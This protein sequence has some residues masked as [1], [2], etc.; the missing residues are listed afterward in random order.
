[1]NHPQQHDHHNLHGGGGPVDGGED[2]GDNLRISDE[3]REDSD[4]FS[5]FPDLSN[6]ANTTTTGIDS[7][8]SDSTLQVPIDT[9][10][11]DAILAREMAELTM[12]DRETIQ[13]SIYGVAPPVNESEES[14][15][16]GLTQFD[17]ILSA[18]EKEANANPS[19]SLAGRM[20]AYLQAKQMNPAVTADRKLRLSFL[21][22]SVWDFK[23][24]ERRIFLFFTKKLNFFG[25]A[26]LTRLI[27]WDDL[28][29]R[30]KALV[31]SGTMSWLPERDVSGR[32]VMVMI[33][34]AIH[35]AESQL[36]EV[37]TDHHKVIRSRLRAWN[38]IWRELVS[39]ETCHLMGVVVVILAYGDL[40]ILK[41][42][43]YIQETHASKDSG[44]FRI[45]A[46]HFCY[47]NPYIRPF[48]TFNRWLMGKD[49]RERNITHY[50][51]DMNQ[52]MRELETY[53]IPT[54]CMPKLLFDKLTGDTT[55]SLEHHQAHID[56]RIE[57]DSLE[58]P[59]E[60]I[61]VPH[62][63]DGKFIRSI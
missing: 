18:R 32:R 4:E 15:A 13:K 38:Y 5:L 36:A 19:S 31:R 51:S 2:I 56:R 59:E 58:D 49:V 39:D 30:E 1:M 22:S 25:E 45:S 63:F 44:P 29:T 48:I 37:E 46:L 20:A 34:T 27:V 35:L 23:E 17:E 14:I 47:H 6:T 11:V 9:E 24:A 16:R 62:R 61:S 3:S 28:S 43:R 42:F 41:D 57:Q 53:G 7:S 40:S 55:L 8:K 10:R 33:P 60:T 12:R 50:S 26:K 54:S 52:V 21:R